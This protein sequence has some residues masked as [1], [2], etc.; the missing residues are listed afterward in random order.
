M[1]G[2]ERR[3]NAY[4]RL[5]GAM[6]A[7]VLSVGA[8]AAPAAPLVVTFED[9]FE[10][11]VLPAGWDYQRGTWDESGGSMNGVPDDAVGTQWKARAFA[12]EAF[13]GCDVCTVTGTL[14]LTNTFGVAA[15]IHARLFGWYVD[16][17]WNV[18]VTLK[19]EQ[20]KVIYRQK[21]GTNK[22][23]KV[24]IQNVDLSAA[25]HGATIDFDGAS[26]HVTVDGVPLLD[27]PTVDAGVFGTV[28]VQSRN[29][30]INLH[31]LTVEEN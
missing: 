30:D 6:A 20:N 17:A 18:S 10:D 15:E 2:K 27:V 21:R 12:T 5:A 1:P 19:P 26:F 13:A 24:T 31:H 3:V 8:A 7:A 11:G 22:T 14:G 29:G 4:R 23:V 25:T 16:R 9:D 28:G